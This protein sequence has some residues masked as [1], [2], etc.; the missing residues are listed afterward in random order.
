[1]V[2]VIRITI[3]L[4]LAGILLPIGIGSWLGYLPNLTGN[5]STIGT[6]FV[7]FALLAVG[8]GFLDVQQLQ[9]LSHSFGSGKGH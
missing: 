1:M 2:N 6:L 3:E 5:N 4:L 7:L 8:L 9:K